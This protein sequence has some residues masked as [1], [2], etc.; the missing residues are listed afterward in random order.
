MWIRTDGAWALRNAGRET[1]P[2][3]GVVFVLLLELS[4]VLIVSLGSRAALGRGLLSSALLAIFSATWA[5]C[6]PASAI[7][8]PWAGPSATLP[9]LLSLP[10]LIRPPL[11]AQEQVLRCQ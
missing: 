6:V 7:H 11:Q 3:P 10:V 8:V 1:E 2:Q 9:S 4:V 5:Q